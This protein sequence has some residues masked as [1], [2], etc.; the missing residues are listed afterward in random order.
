MACITEVF[1]YMKT[2]NEERRR[3]LD[4]WCDSQACV[5]SGGGFVGYDTIAHGEEVESMD[6]GVEY[7][8]QD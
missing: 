7:D 1:L 2:N 6:M 8:A 5:K 4:K 3:I